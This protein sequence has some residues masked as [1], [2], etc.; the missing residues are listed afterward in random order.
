MVNFYTDEDFAGLWGHENYQEPI[1]AMS[2]NGFVVTFSNFP[3]FWV[4][5]L[6]TEISLTTLH[7][8]YVALSHYVRALLPLKS[9][10]KE[11][12]DNLGIDC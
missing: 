10:I 3:L 11:A 6:Q 2:R 7:S 12:I 8:E 9:I 5:K 4:S 1:C